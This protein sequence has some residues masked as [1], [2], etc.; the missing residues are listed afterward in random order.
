MHTHNQM[1]YGSINQTPIDDY[2]THWPIT[3]V[4]KKFVSL[5]IPYSATRLLDVASEIT[6]S[7]LFAK[8]GG[9]YLA[10]CGLIIPMQ[11][12]LTSTVTSFLFSMGTLLRENKN[13]PIKI[14]QITRDGI[15]ISLIVSVPP[16]MLAAG[17]EPLLH[18]IG[19]NYEVSKIVGNFYL[20]ALP[21]ISL[22]AIQSALQQFTL[23]IE[24]PNISLFFNTIN[25]LIIIGGG[26][27]LTLGLFGA[28]KM[29]ERGL[30]IA[31]SSAYG[32]TTLGTLFYL[33]LHPSFKQYNLASRLCYQANNFLKDIFKL[34]YPL[35]I[36]VASDYL[37]RY[38][39]AV[40]IGWRST[41]EL[42]MAR[43]IEMIYVPVFTVIL[44][45][46]QITCNLTKD[47]LKCNNLTLM[48]QITGVNIGTLLLLTGIWAATAIFSAKPIIGLFLDT[49]EPVNQLS[50][51]TAEQ[52][53]WIYPLG[54]A[55]ETARYA[56]TGSLRGLKD[57]TTSM[58]NSLGLL[59]VIGI[60]LLY[61]G[62]HFGL[63]TSELYA[64][65][66]A[67]FALAALSLGI[68]WGIK[69]E[70][71]P[72]NCFTSLWNTCKS[73]TPSLFQ[74]QNTVNFLAEEVK[75]EHNKQTLNV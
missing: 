67:I 55:A 51:K 13:D 23:G 18:A 45:S 21:S 5:S 25:N 27:I 56:F 10:A 24:R 6:G 28:P 19:M 47:A 16:L 44:R 72:S 12:F 39:L 31:Y 36:Q 2:A 63:N 68:Q 22:S 26:T 59:I 74:R 66:T 34:G 61:L 73:W 50:I 64:I 69:I 53:M 46:P 17:I 75:E 52:L 43:I 7:V 54:L 70:N 15:L 37:M 35:G 3:K 30:G 38:A 42:A 62:Y 4:T 33:C 32:L 14:G 1:N 20:V 57:T 40:M 29:D 41:S 71:K 48:K 9:Q 65:S 8:L 49:N 60:P 58:W 11:R